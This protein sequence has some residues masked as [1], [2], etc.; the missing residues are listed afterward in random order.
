MTATACLWL[1]WSVGGG[2]AQK[3][4]DTGLH[5]LVDLDSIRRDADGLVHFTQRILDMRKNPLPPKTSA[6]DCAK[7]VEYTSTANPGWRSQGF[8]VTPTSRGEELLVYVC[9]R[10]PRAASGPPPPIAASPAGTWRGTWNSSAGYAYA[11]DV[12]LQV[13]ADGAV[14]GSIVWTLRV[15]PV[16]TDQHKIGMTG[17]ERV[18]GTFDARSGTISM[19]GFEKNDPNTIIGLD[20]YRLFY[21][22]NGKVIGGIT[23]SH[24]TWEGVLS[25]VRSGPAR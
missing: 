3:W 22:E 8:E 1:L 17:V 10:A 15:T 23:E 9:A 16:T 14:E 18:R 21:A 7:R 11:A 19:R 24:G 6:Y 13:A 5:V 2:A 4:V 20:R 25:L 12:R